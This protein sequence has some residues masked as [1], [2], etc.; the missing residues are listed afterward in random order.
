[1]E[2]VDDEPIAKDTN[3]VLANPVGNVELMRLNWQYPVGYDDNIIFVV[4]TNTLEESVIDIWMLVNT[5]ILL[6]T[7]AL[8]PEATCDNDN[9]PTSRTLNDTVVFALETV[10]STQDTP[11]SG[12]TQIWYVPA[13]TETTGETD[14]WMTEDI[15]DDDEIAVMP[16]SW[17]EVW[18]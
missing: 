18:Q 17:L 1:M 6:A 15:M 2:L 4:E 10:C 11:W 16:K 5:L 12:E 8:T 3:W 7:F 13:W 14:S 9:V